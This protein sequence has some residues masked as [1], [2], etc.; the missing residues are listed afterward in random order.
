MPYYQWYAFDPN[1]PEPAPLK[2][3]TTEER[4]RRYAE[5]QDPHPEWDDDT[6]P[7]ADDDAGSGTLT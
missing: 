5:E 7:W 3:E 1:I 4:A 2:Q 6:D